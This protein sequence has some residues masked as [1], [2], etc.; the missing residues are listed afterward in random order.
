[1]HIAP[2]L[3]PA[4]CDKNRATQ[5]IEN[6]LSNAAKYTPRGGQITVKTA[7]AQEEGFLEIAVIDNGVG[8][9]VEDQAKIFSRF[10]R[11]KSAAAVG[12]SGAGLGLYITRS[13]V[14]LHGGRIW[15][16]SKLGE[17]STFHAT[18]PIAG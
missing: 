3:P 2:D 15:F 4:L 10:F 5:I 18:F 8:I 1:L 9:S 16:E 6:L 12:A 11:T 17:G 13:L 7:P 14:E